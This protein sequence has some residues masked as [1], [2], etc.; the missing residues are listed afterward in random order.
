MTHLDAEINQLK[1]SIIEMWQLVIYQLEK[2]QQVLSDF[3]KGLIQDIK[4]NEKLVDSFELKIDRDCENILALY[5]PVAVDLRF[6][7]SVLKI[8]YNLE[9]IG[10]YANSVSKMIEDLDSPVNN[11][12]LKNTRVFEMYSLIQKLMH[13]SLESFENENNT[14]ARNI[15]GKDKEIN[16]INKASTR[17]ISDYIISKP[18]EVIIAMNLLSVIRKL[19][20]AGDHIQNIAEEIIFYLEAK[21]MKHNKAKKK[22]KGDSL[23]ENKP[24]DFNMP[25]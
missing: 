6:V 12:L 19:E 14:L 5:N 23:P 18:E 25:A 3:D 17:I 10:D 1:A 20:R 21:V 7:L 24:D 8:N 11:E 22:H 9:R 15:F 16:K 4:I 2:S 13:D